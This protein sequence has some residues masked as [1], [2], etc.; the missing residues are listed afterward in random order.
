MPPRRAAPAASRVATEDCRPS[1]DT[2]II[3][4]L[5]NVYEYVLPL[6][7]NV[8]ALKDFVIARGQV[9]IMFHKKTPGFSNKGITVLEGTE[10]KWD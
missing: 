3:N 8:G 9:K 5:P 10:I 4:E 7:D 1:K 6:G 2:H